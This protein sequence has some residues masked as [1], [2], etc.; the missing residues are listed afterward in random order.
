M[1]E[2]SEH[3]HTSWTPYDNVLLWVEFRYFN[4]SYGVTGTSVHGPFPYDKDGEKNLATRITALKQDDKDFHPEDTEL[5][6]TVECAFRED[7][8][9]LY[10]RDGTPMVL[11]TGYTEDNPDVVS[12][13]KNSTREEAVLYVVRSLHLTGAG[14]RLDRTLHVDRGDFADDVAKELEPF[15]VRGGKWQNAGTET[16]TFLSKDESKALE[17]AEEM[18]PKDTRY[19]KLLANYEVDQHPSKEHTPNV[20]QYQDRS[21]LAADA[22]SQHEERPASERVLGSAQDSGS[23]KGDLEEQVIRFYVVTNSEMEVLSAVTITKVIVAGNAIRYPTSV[24]KRGG[25]DI[26]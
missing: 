24:W 15:I 22:G 26:D 12:A 14:V 10:R 17:F 4:T 20:G 2:E 6:E 13:I 25:S 7:S 16:R 11:I 18:A 1:A 5:E 23:E 3:T 19:L 21:A 8:M 9:C